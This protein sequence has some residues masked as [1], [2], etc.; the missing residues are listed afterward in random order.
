MGRI[1]EVGKW[2]MEKEASRKGI[3]ELSLHDDEEVRP[4]LDIPVRQI[5]APLA[6][7][8][9]SIDGSPPST[10]LQEALRQEAY[11]WPR[12]IFPPLKR[13]GHIILDC[14]TAEG[15]TVLLI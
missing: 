8:S 1:G 13:S 7:L 4:G 14:C 12:L 9:A 3:R 2:E 10:E 15:R 11:S 6:D 5:P